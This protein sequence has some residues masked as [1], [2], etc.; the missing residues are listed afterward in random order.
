MSAIVSGTS[1]YQCGGYESKN[2]ATILNTLRCPGC[3]KALDWSDRY[4]KCSC[5]THNDID[6]NECYR[7]NSRK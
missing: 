3:G 7:C 1:C 2:E 5:G 6:S 4:W